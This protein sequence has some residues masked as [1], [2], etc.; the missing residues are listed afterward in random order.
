MA[1]QKKT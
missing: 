1:G